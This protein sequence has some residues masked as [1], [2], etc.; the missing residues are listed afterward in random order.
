MLPCDAR[1][2][3]AAGYTLLPACLPAV[4]KG[5]LDLHNSYRARHGVPALS[6]SSSVAATAQSHSSRCVFQHSSGS[7]YGENIGQVRST[8][9]VG[10]S[11]VLS[12]SI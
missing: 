7:G 1:P 8:A 9:H 11:W 5:V 6:W 3:P 2:N 10:W 4:M 12:L